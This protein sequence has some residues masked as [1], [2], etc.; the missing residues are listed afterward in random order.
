MEAELSARALTLLKRGFREAVAILV[1]VVAILMFI[2]LVTF[3][4]SDPSWSH[5]GGYGQVKNM[6]GIFG[7][8]FADVS[9]FL[10]GLSLIHISE[11]TRPY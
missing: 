1:A 11:P 2:S 8:W 4:V 6:G 5:T 7:A 9:M 3:H 10:F